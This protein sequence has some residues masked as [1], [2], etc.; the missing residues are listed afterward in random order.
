MTVIRKLT[1]SG[2][3]S[4]SE[5]LKRL[6]NGE[7]LDPPLHLLDGQESSEAL[8]CTAEV[9]F[10]KL[11]TKQA[12]AKYLATQLSTLDTSEVDNDIGLWSWLS[13]FYFEQ[14]V[15]PIR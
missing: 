10:V 8:I 7:T 13:L 11:E 14:T 5:Y 1:G 6:A 4:F 2:I 3:A 15:S 12:A 9:E